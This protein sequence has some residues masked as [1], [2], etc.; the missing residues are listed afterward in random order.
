MIW[1]D[2]LGWE[3]TGHGSRREGD[4]ITQKGQIK[5][6]QQM[7]PFTKVPSHRGAARRRNMSLALGNRRLLLA[8]F[9]SVVSRLQN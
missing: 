4:E 2:R 7:P 3:W 1:Q 8:K 9:F 5:E 6:C